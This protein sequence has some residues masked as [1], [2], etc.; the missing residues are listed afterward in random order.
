MSR[1]RKI[2]GR[3]CIRILCNKLGFQIAR[4]RGSHYV[5]RKDGFGTV[6]PL[7]EELKIS[8]LKSILKLGDV[9]EE[10][11]SEYL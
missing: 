9:D 6:V 11:F 7:H 5:L 8:T 2:S 10:E 3:K 1:L 4:K